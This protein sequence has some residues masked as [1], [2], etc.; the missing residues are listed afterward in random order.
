M[1]RKTAEGNCYNLLQYYFNSSTDK[2]ELNYD[3][4]PF[5]NLVQAVWDDVESSDYADPDIT[6]FTIENRILELKTAP[7]DVSTF[8]SSLVNLVKTSFEQNKGEHFVIIPL[9]G[10]KLNKQITFGDEMFYLIP[11]EENE[12]TLFSNLSNIMS[13]EYEKCADMFEHTK[14]SRS[15][16][17]FKHNLLLIRI[18]DQ[19][20][21]VRSE[22]ITI[23]V[24]TIYLMHT[25]YWTL[26]TTE[27]ALFTLKKHSFDE[28]R[29]NYHVLIMSDDEWRCGHGH[30]WN[31]GLPK[32]QIDLHFLEEEE[33]QTIFSHLFTEFLLNPGDELT[34]RFVNSLILLNRGFHFEFKNDND[35]ATLL[36]MT[37][38]EALLTEQKNE[39]RLRLAAILSKLIYIEGKTRSEIAD[40][41]DSVYY[42]RNDFVHAGKSPFYEYREDEEDELTFTRIAIS[43]LILKYNEIDTLLSTQSED[44]RSKKWDAYVDQIFKTLIF[45]T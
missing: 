32:C 28:L 42:K 11:S 15:R 31:E 20:S 19:T 12:K 2:P 26:N 38:A 39:K 7:S 22:A 8:Y 41:L 14:N 16:D 40:I 3:C 25:L 17:F 18:E 43:K 27:D 5:M 33:N 10:S 44:N 29:E 30:T 37:S 34:R 45:G 13:I 36:Y 9:H 4:K 23:A 1:N 24:R 35:L 6:I 21:R